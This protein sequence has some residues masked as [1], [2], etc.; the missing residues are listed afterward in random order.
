MF[1]FEPLK[2]LTM[3]PLLPL[4]EMTLRRSKVTAAGAAGI[5]PMVLPVPLMTAMPF[6]LLA[7]AIAPFWLVPMKFP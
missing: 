6:E 4:P 7:I 5:P 2:P 3:I 1:V